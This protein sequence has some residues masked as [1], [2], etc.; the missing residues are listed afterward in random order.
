MYVIE[1]KFKLG[2]TKFLIYGREVDTKK[3]IFLRLKLKYQFSRT[4]FFSDL[5]HELQ[6]EPIKSE[7]TS[8]QDSDEDSAEFKLPRNINYQRKY[9]CEVET[10][11][12]LCYTIKQLRLPCDNTDSK[13]WILPLLLTAMPNLTSLGETKLNSLFKIL[14]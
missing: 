8:D 4:Y 11:S 13:S 10:K 6:R 3:E 12:P 5:I 2:Q 1:P 9:V 14:H 7:E